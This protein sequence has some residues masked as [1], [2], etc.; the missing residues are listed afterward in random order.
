[1]LYSTKKQVVHHS[2]VGVLGK[3]PFILALVGTSKQKEHVVGKCSR[4]VGL[5]YIHDHTW[6]S[7]PYP[8]L[9]AEVCPSESY[10]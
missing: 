7:W 2:Q 9:G 6:H 8:I 5:V 1:M 4:L 10:G 3:E